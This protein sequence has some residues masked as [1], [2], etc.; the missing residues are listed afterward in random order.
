MLTQPTIPR[1]GLPLWKVFPGVEDGTG[2]QSDWTKLI[3]QHAKAHHIPL[4]YLH[5]VY[6][7]NEHESRENSKEIGKPAGGI[8][9]NGAVNG[10]GAGRFN[11]YIFFNKRGASSRHVL[12]CNDEL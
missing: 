12:V 3:K 6:P 7:M 9:I 1:D 8:R 10:F 5:A 11:L 2:E 4:K